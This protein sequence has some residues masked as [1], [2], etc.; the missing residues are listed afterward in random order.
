MLDLHYSRGVVVVRF[1]PEPQRRLD[2]ELLDRLSAAL[3]YI[4]SE[5]SIV[6]T[7]TGTTFAPDLPAEDGL[8]RAHASA[9]LA[10]VRNVLLA[11]PLPV[12]AAINGDAIGA[13]WALAEAADVRIMSGGVVQPAGAP[14]ARYRV[15]AAVAARLVEYSCLPASLLADA[16]LLAGRLEPQVVTTG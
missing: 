4:G 3:A 2:P 6:L 12:V 7:G 5:R 1:R 16:V 13:G 11:H 8:A 9:R 14:V 10:R 15:K